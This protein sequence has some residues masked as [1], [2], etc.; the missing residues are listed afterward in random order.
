MRFYNVHVESASG[1]DYHE[2]KSAFID[3]VAGLDGCRKSFKYR[4]GSFEA[5]ACW[6]QDVFTC[7]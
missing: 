7:S 6:R 2:R 3:R 4:F 1:S 5:L